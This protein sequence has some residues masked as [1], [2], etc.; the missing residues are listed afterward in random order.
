MASGVLGDWVLP[1]VYNITIRGM[2]A[3][4]L[5]WLFFGGLIAINRIL[6][7]QRKDESLSERSSHARAA[8]SN[9]RKS[10]AQSGSL[11]QP[12]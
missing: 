7:H 10:L 3:S 12:S 11:Q 4:I 5:P 2:R 9:E 1:Y 8:L 6:D